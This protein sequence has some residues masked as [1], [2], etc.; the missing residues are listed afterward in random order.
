MSAL[1]TG[2]TSTVQDGPL[3]AASGVAVPVSI[4]RFVAFLRSHARVV[5]QSGGAFLIVFGLLTVTGEW[6]RWMV[7]LRAWPGNGGIEV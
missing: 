1:A 5:G 6:N 3:I 2:F 7:A 4:I